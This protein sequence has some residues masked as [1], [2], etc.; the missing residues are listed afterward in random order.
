MKKKELTTTRVS[1]DQDGKYR[2][3]YVLNMYR[4]PAILVVVL[5]IIGGLFSIPFIIDLI[6]TAVRGDWA[7]AWGENIW[8]SS[9]KIWL[10]VW[11]V[12]IVI[13][14]LAYL[15]VAWTYGGKY[16]VHFTMDEKTLVHETEPAQASKA[17]KLGMATVIVGAAARR[18]GTMGAGMLAAARTKST[19]T[20]A[21]V[22][23]IIPRRR[24]NLI[25][26]NQ[27]LERNQVYVPDEDYDFVLSFLF[28]HCPEAKRSMSWTSGL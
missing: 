26:V 27:L 11:V 28:D 18:P 6:R 1:H 3:T 16:I 9:L 24:Y 25:K 2:W 10:V 8:D 20:L 22:R 23:R 13:S 15:I 21:S 14:L 5:K 12:F 7:N 19:S 4:N 17:R